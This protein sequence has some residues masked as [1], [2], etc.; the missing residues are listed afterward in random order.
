MEQSAM[1]VPKSDASLAAFL[2]KAKRSTIRAGD[3]FG[4]GRT[5]TH[6]SWGQFLAARQAYYDKVD[7][8]RAAGAPD[9]PLLGHP[10]P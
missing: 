6:Q 8:L 7:V 10:R 5:I 2:A 4:C 3:W 1:T 9:D